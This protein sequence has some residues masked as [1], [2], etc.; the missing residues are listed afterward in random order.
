VGSN[1]LEITR[2]QDGVT[3]SPL[4]AQ[5]IEPDGIVSGIVT[6]SKGGVYIAHTGYVDPQTHT[7]IGG[8]DSNGNDNAIVV[9][10]FP[11]G[12]NMASP[13][14][15]T[16]NQTLCQMRAD[17]CTTSIVYTAP[18]FP[19]SPGNSTVIVG[20]DFSPIAIDRAGNLYVVWSQ[21]SADPSTGMINGTSQVYMA[22]S[23]NHGATWGPPVRVTAAT[24]SLQTNL[25]AWVAAGDPG[26]VDVVWYGTPTLGSCPNQPCGSGAITAH[27]QVMLAQSLNAIVNGA[28]NPNPSF[29]TAQVSEVSNHYGQIC[30][31][32]IGCTTGGDRGLLDF[33]SVTV[34]HQGEANVVWA[35]AVN[36]N[37]VMGTS[38]ALISFSRQVA[39]PSLYANVGQVTGQSPASGAGMGSPDAF[40]SADGTATLGTGNL[41]LQSAAVTMPD[42]QHFRFTINVSDLSTLFVPPTLGGTDA[43]WMVRWEVPDP[44]GTGHTYFA[45]MESD[46]G[47]A[48]T[49][50]DGETL[51]L[52]SSHGKFLTYNPANSIQGSFA[53]SSTGGVITLNVPVA[54]VGGNPNATLYSITG[55]TA[56][57]LTASSTGSAGSSTTGTST[58]PIFNQIDATEPFDFT[59]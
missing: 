56:T 29:V 38:S 10:I 47:Q 53:A 9:V 23:S 48:P 2:S 13:I 50:F 6:D 51:A 19:G 24:P 16:G 41:I 40:Y 11:K 4:P 20:Q 46:A 33:I 43:V 3:F 34:G 36:R 21:A 22:V 14:P 18:L 15:L 39:G 58:G 7:I 30:T 8:A 35:D 54:D 45:A 25:F 5:Q 42:Q 37:S 26:R 28:P 49:F 31:F 59:P 1:M 52:S 44:N 57:Q 27:W 55:V 32:G 17:V 12:Y